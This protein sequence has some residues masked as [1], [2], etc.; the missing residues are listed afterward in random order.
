MN[1]LDIQTIV[2]QFEFDD[3]STSYCIDEH[4]VMS[5][6]KDEGKNTSALKSILEDGTK[7]GK[8]LFISLPP[9]VSD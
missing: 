7:R 4:L 1:T 3:I 2:S 5:I 9:H 6:M 8:K